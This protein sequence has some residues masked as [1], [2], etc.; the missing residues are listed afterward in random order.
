MEQISP[1][2]AYISKAGQEDPLASYGT[3]RFITMF[4]KIHHWTPFWF[5]WTQPITSQLKI[6]LN[7]IHPS[8]DVCNFS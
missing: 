1:S 3:R 5:T 6:Y 7:I 8:Y 4:T 2:D